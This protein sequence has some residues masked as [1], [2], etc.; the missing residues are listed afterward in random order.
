MDVCVG[1][2]K[3]LPFYKNMFHCITDYVHMATFLQKCCLPRLPLL[4]SN[5]ILFVLN[6]AQCH[7][8]NNRH[9]PRSNIP[10][11]SMVFIGHIFICPPCFCSPLL[12]PFLPPSITRFPFCVLPFCSAAERRRILTAFSHVTLR[13]SLRLTRKSS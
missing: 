5:A 4:Q 3:C 1:I 12:H 7:V 8:A 6:I 10:S 2:Y 11:V 13:C 9:M